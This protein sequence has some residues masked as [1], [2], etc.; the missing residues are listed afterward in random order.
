MDF[1][2]AGH[3]QI[4][5]KTLNIL[6]QTGD[7]GGF[8]DGS[9]GTDGLVVN[10]DAALANFSLAAALFT[11]WT[12]GT[13]TITIT[14]SALDNVIIG[15]SHADRMIGGLGSDSYYV[16]N[17]LD[18]TDESTGGGAAD[19]VFSSVSFTAA[20]GIEQLT[21]TGAGDINGT[22]RDAQNDA[23]IGNGGLNQLFGFS[24]D[25]A[26]YG[27]GGGDQLYGGAGNDYLSG[28]DQADYM[29]GGAG[30]DTFFGGAG[31]DTIIGGAGDDK[32]YILAGDGGDI[33]VDYAGEGNDRILSSISYSL[34]SG[35]EIETLSTDAN[36]GTVAINLTGNTLNNSIIGNNGVNVLDGGLGNDTLYGLG[37][38]VDYFAFSTVANTATNSD[39][40]ADWS[41]AG[42][43]I[44]L[45]DAAFTGM[46]AGTLAVS[47][48]LSGAGLTAA[49]TAAQHVIVNTTNGDLWWDQDGVGGIASV[50]FASIGAGQAVF[51]YD[52]FGI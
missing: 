45:D 7:L 9:A 39:V 30:A 11:Q 28:G 2:H 43:L 22:G 16:D 5:G 14:G 4:G 44:F 50:R 35:S 18:V 21:L 52:F 13:D 25:D 41:S 29:S 47:A 27:L 49:A 26:L 34:S 48:F 15:S 40:I 17:A 19:F 37:G 42:D 6:H 51:Y 24:G 36:I 31:T 38:A 1:T 12:D 10:M 23:L 20:A 3:V 33:I 46:A 32:F 8:F